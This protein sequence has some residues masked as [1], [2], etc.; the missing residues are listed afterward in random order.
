[1]LERLS[2][3]PE[4]AIR[5]FKLRSG[6][7]GEAAVGSRSTIAIDLPQVEYEAADKDRGDRHDGCV[8]HRFACQC[9][10]RQERKQIEGEE[11]HEVNRSISE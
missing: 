2:K 4:N 10:N 6:K 8:K 3:I 7:I 5:D 9:G 1:M 11:N